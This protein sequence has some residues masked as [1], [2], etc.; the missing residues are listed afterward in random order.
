MRIGSDAASWEVL[1]FLFTLNHELG[2]G[3]DEKGGTL[4]QSLILAH[5]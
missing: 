4:S 3:V 5:H 1:M 2:V